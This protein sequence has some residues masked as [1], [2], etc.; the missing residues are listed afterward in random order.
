MPYRPKDV[1]KALKRAGF[2]QV[3]QSGSH[4]MME[5]PSDNRFVVVPVHTKDL[6]KGTFFSIL[7]MA[8]FTEAQLQELL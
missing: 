6:P 5:H 1:I 4:V 2:K 3:R 8:Q 7:K